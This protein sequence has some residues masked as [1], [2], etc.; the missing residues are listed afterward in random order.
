MRDIICMGASAG[1]VQALKTLVQTIPK[2]LRASIFVVLHVPA[3]VPSRLSEILT[4]AGPWPAHVP[5][6]GERFV[7]GVIYVAPPDSHMILEK[8]TISVVR[9]PKENRSRPA[10]DPLFRS[11][12]QHHASR[13]IGVVLSGTLDDGK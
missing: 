8:E 6:N 7:H 1:G 11:A 5:V 10:V 9:G 2:T 3:Y 13:A 12:A 4:A